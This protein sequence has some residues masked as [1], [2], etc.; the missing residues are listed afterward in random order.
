MLPLAWF[1][2]DLIFWSAFPSRLN[3]LGR[4]AR[5]TTLSELLAYGLNGSSAKLLKVLVALVLVIFLSLYTSAQWLAGQKFLSTAFEFSDLPAL[6]F[7]S[8]TIIA[9]SALGGFRGSVYA[10]TLQA[11][12]SIVG[13]CAAIG[14]VAWLAMADMSSFVENI[15]GA[16]PEFLDPSPSAS[17]LGVLGFF[18]GFAS[19]SLGFGLGQ[20]QVVTRYFAGSSPEETRA[21]R[22]IYMGFLQFTWISMTLFGVMLRG[23]MPDIQD[24]ETGLSVFFKE[25]MSPILVGLTFAYV[26]AII[27][28]TANSIVVSVAQSAYRDILTVFAPPVEEKRHTPF[29]VILAI[30]IITI[31]LSFIVPGNVFSIAIGAVSKI[32]AGIAGPVIV[33]TLR[34]K[35]TSTSLI[36]AISAGIGAAIVW[37]YIG[38]SLDFNEA[39]IGIAVSLS[40]NWTISRLGGAERKR[41]KP[42]RDGIL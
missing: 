37:E 33:K 2:G 32:G 18:A 15:R 21:A 29:L 5:A 3:K 26:F 4:T 30:G 14:S 38:L 7:F 10:D 20:P 1:L 27:A 34:W 40:V 9:Y 11:V 28:S 42:R 25:N 16:G 12:V 35:H 36:L 24:A 23:I 13:T 31:G 22:W 19:A 6:I 8:C 17:F 39:G 41:G